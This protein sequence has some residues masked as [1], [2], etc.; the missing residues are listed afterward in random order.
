[1]LCADYHPPSLLAAPFVDT[2][3][4]LP[5][6]VNRVTRNPADAAG[7]DDRGR[8][9][10]GARADVIVVDPEPTP[11]V[12]TVLV[13]GEEVVRA[14]RESATATQPAPTAGS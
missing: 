14:S 8:I 12:E 5:T 7:L 13:Q 9:E 1:V 4:D 3:E 11:T 6:R 10:V 2:G